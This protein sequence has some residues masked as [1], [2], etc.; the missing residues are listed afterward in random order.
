MPASLES[1][2]PIMAPSVCFTLLAAPRLSCLT[3][4]TPIASRR[5]LGA[6][7]TL[8]ASLLNSRT[9]PFAPTFLAP[10][11]IPTLARSLAFAPG[12]STSASELLAELFPALANL[13]H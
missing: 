9:S 10:F 7:T 3:P 5:P 6:F 13:S 8:S 11:P 1:S 4:P 2:R 12:T